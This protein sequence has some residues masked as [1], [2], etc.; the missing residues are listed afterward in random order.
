MRVDSV[1]RIGPNRIVVRPTYSKRFATQ[2]RENGPI[3]WA[4]LCDQG[5]PA[6]I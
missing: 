5:W 3:F 4:I 2:S 1:L 6:R